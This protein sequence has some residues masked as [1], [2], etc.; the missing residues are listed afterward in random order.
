[1]FKL[2]VIVEDRPQAAQVLVGDIE[3]AITTMSGEWATE[4]FDFD[5]K[6]DLTFV[7]MFKLDEPVEMI[8]QKV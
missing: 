1:M 8:F 3:V 6:G 5:H 7:K 4:Q 2:Q